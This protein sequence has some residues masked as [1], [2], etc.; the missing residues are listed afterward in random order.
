MNISSVVLRARPADLVQVRSALAALPGVEVHAAT[1]EG[2][3]VITVE[4][5]ATANAADTFVRLH[6]I[7]GVMS[8]AMVYHYSDD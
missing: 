4:D 5:A 7:R 3:V 6:E 8:V 2:R 1:G